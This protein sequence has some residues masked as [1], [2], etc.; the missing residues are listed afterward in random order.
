MAENQP[1]LDT[2]IASLGERIER[3]Q[4]YL[5]PE[6]PARPTPVPGA[7]PITTVRVI[8]GLFAVA[9]GLLLLQDVVA[10]C[11]TPDE[12]VFAAREEGRFHVWRNVRAFEA[13]TGKKWSEH[14]PGEA[15]LLASY[16]D[17]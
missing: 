13:S 6:P 4:R 3:L 12:F 10:V 1:S 15:D 11:F 2:R 14:A 9:A 7:N 5:P 17:A 8:L 16:H